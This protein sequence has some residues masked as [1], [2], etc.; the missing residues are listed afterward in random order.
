MVSIFH[1]LF[2]TGIGTEHGGVVDRAH[3][4]LCKFYAVGVKVVNPGSRHG[5]TWKLLIDSNHG[6]NG[7]S[8]EEPST[9]T[10]RSALTLTVPF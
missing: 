3:I 10:W 6:S 5:E 8:N 1:L 4:G 7:S 9:Y 2:H